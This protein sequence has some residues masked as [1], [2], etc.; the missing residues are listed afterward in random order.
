MIIRIPELSDTLTLG[1]VMAQ[2]WSDLYGDV[3]Q[4][5]QPES[6][7]PD[8][9]PCVLLLQGDLGAGKTTLVRMLVEN[10]PGG[11]EA[12]VSS[13]SF[14]LCNSYATA[15]EV[16]HFDLYRLEPWQDDDELADALEMAENR[17]LLLIIEW[18]ERMKESLLPVELVYCSLTAGASGR[19]AAFKTRNESGRQFLQL[20]ARRAQTAGLAVEDS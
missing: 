5:H 15:P 17:D 7:L 6:A 20:L 12:E 13:P 9:F 18:P 8:E 2:L 10:L 1:M 3:A 11:K 16:L 14:T 4:N 19:V